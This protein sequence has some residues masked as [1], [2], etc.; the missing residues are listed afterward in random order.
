MYV[1]LW[2]PDMLS[3]QEKKRLHWEEM[4]RKGYSDSKVDTHNA[5]EGKDSLRDYDH[6]FRQP[7]S[8]GERLGFQQSKGQ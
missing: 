8:A 6:G 2:A 3:S 1:H 5:E 7:G 4:Q